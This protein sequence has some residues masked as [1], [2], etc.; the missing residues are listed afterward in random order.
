MRLFTPT[1]ARVLGLGALATLAL[2]GALN[3]P[4]QAEKSQDCYNNTTS[5]CQTVETCSGGFEPNGTC[6]WVYTIKRY[7]WKY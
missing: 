5:V 4:A 6:K 1:P 3:R 7:Y 2:L